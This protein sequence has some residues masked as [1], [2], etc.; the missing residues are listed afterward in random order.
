MGSW[1][2][3]KLY[4]WRSRKRRRSSLFHEVTGV[5]IVGT[6]QEKWTKRNGFFFLFLSALHFA[7]LFCLSVC[8]SVCL[9]NDYPRIVSGLMKCQ[10]TS[11]S[12]FLVLIYS[13]CSLWSRQIFQLRGFLNAM[14]VVLRLL[15]ITLFHFILIILLAGLELFLHFAFLV[16]HVNCACIYR[17]GLKR[18]LKC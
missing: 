17:P 1:L 15:F 16:C 11:F 3:R 6:A 5:Q 2:L 13:C 9:S 10:K 4:F 7:P 8:L 14:F 12:N 18:L